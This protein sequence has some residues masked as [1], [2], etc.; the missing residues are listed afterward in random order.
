MSYFLKKLN[1]RKGV[2]LILTFMVTTVLFISCGVFVNMAVNQ[3]LTADIFKRRTKAFYMAEAGLDHAIY[4]LRA[5]GQPPIGDK[6][7]PWGGV[8]EIKEGNYSVTIT[9]LGII[10]GTGTLR[11]Y[12][13]TSIG[14][15]G[16]KSRVLTNYVQVDNYARYL[17]F[18][19]REIYGGTNV[20]FWSQDHLNGPT[21]TN[22]HF[23]IYGTPYLKTKCVQLM[24]ISD[25]TITAITL[26]C[27]RLPTLLLTYRIFS[28]E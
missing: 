9:D 19:D 16:N 7:N 14:T 6:T 28:R 21:H 22:G 17:W 3:N 5:Q 4:W 18:T 2:A 20:W 12:K 27:S 11:R 25:S 15:F 26:T 10:G 8:Q 23:N 13:V 1:N 24:T